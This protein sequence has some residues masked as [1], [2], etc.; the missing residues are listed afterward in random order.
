MAL[1]HNNKSIRD[2]L[3]CCWLRQRSSCVQ[4]QKEGREPK[5]GAA[6][7]GLTRITGK[8]LAERDRPGTVT[9]T[10]PRRA[11]VGLGQGGKGLG[12]V[13]P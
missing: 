12:A 6:E 8:V 7:S 9:V 4:W 5:K 3:E 13:C 11:L 10:A 1:N 2:V